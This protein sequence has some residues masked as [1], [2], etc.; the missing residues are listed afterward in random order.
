MTTVYVIENLKPEV[1][2]FLD[3]SV[4]HLIMNSPVSN[5]KV[6]VVSIPRTKGLCPISV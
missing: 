4:D 1:Q 6:T 5:L 2:N 3:Y